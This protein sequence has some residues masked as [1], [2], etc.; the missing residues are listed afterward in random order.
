MLYL[1]HSLA[2]EFCVWV[3]VVLM[4]PARGINLKTFKMTVTVPPVMLA[5]LNSFSLLF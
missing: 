2:G 1:P 4:I 5:V 3:K